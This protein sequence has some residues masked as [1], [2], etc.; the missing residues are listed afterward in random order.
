MAPKKNFYAVLFKDGTHRIYSNWPDC[1][2]ATSGVPDI[3][4]KGFITRD[5]ATAWI[6]LTVPSDASLPIEA[7]KEEGFPPGSVLIYVDG[8]YIHKRCKRAGWA[9][10]AVKDDKVIGQE[11][12]VTEKDALSRN[13]DGELEAAVKA[14]EWARHHGH[15]AVIHHDYTGISMWASGAWKVKAEISQHYV[16]RIKDLKAGVTFK[17][18]TGHSGD[19]YNDRVDKLAGEAIAA[20][21]ERGKV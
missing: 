8:S 6:A 13:I 11:S 18:V 10:L 14:M 15:K 16:D 17:K 2:R 19:I 20:F 5:E 7:K 9:W 12:G 4:F 21:V 1:Q 3:Q